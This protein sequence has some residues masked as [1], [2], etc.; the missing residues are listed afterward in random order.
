MRIERVIDFQNIVAGQ[1]AIMKPALGPTYE[2]FYLQL[3]GG[4]LITHFDRITIKVDAKPVFETTGADLLAHN[5]YEGISNSTSQVVLDFTMRGAK[6]A[7]TPKGPTSQAAE[8]LLTCL[9][10][11]LFQMMTI[12]FAINASAPSGIG[13]IARAQVSEPSGNPY[14]L[15]QQKAAY[16]FAAAGDQYMP[17]PTGNNG[18]LVK[19]IFLMQTNAGTV[20]ATSTAYAL[21]AQVV[22]N[23]NLYKATAAGTS[24]S[25][26]AGPSGTGGAIT[27]GTVTWAYVSVAPG[28]I[29]AIEVRNNGVIITE[30]QPADLSLV[31]SQF[32][33]VQQANMTVLDYFLQGLRAKLLNTVAGKN[34][35]LKLTTTGGPVNLTVYNRIV[36]PVNRK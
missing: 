24:A 23:G 27:D 10:S 32:G 26:G 25:T 33:R 4:L 28:A 9:P 20:W 15:K 7:G 8:T 13:I 5:L 2:A 11:N 21:N 14:I 12:E 22:A 18:A 36:D 6:S 30:A 1:V 19:D 17:L 3:S 29:S 16:A 35:Y 34:T 31:Q